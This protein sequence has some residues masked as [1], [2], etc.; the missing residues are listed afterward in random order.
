[1]KTVKKKPIAVIY[2]HFVNEDNDVKL[3]K[4]YSLIFSDIEKELLR[5]ANLKQ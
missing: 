2:K 3:R 4:I 1:M 5:S